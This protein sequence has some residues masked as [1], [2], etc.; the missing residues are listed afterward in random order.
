MHLSFYTLERI[1]RERHRVEIPRQQLVQW[2]GH[3]AGRLSSALFCE[4]S[5]VGDHKVHSLDRAMQ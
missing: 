5:S 3:L 4:E 2:V 1:F